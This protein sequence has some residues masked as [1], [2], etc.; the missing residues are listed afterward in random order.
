MRAVEEPK[1]PAERAS[2]PWLP[3]LVC[4][5]VRLLAF[6][7][8]LIAPAQAAESGPTTAGAPPHGGLE[9]KLAVFDGYFYV[10]IAED[11]YPESIPR[12]EDGSI[13]QSNVGFF[14]LYPLTVRILDVA[15]PGGPAI[16]ALLI[17]TA[18][19]LVATWLLWDLVRSISGDEAATR[20][21][22][23]FA[24]FPGA[25]VFSLAYTEAFVLALSIGAILAARRRSWWLAGVLALIASAT[26]PDALVLLVPL[27]WA[28]YVAVRDRRDWRAIAAPALA[29]LGAIAAV[30]AVDRQVG[31]TA[32]YLKV[33]NEAWG[34]GFDFGRATASHTLDVVQAIFGME[35]VT[36][37]TVQHPIGLLFCVLALYA[38]WRWRPPV[39]LWL[40]TLA[41]LVTAM[42]PYS[43]VPRVILRAFP[44][45]AAVGVALKGRW[46]IAVAIGF[47]VIQCVLAYL[48]VSPRALDGAWSF[49]P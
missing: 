27:G 31:E 7:A 36:F 49:I 45:V 25:F 28:A 2:R 5:A 11:G 4:G 12:L 9:G 17:S 42:N 6:I 26:R 47:A 41:S 14:P 24:V 21:A 10:S 30:L 19:A 29:P 44:L 40:Y 18:S 38:M 8:I 34:M 37:Y 48:I 23:L 39:D 46:F 33:Q 43:L 3:L 22:V 35:S 13:A 1:T 20:A 32:S 16:A 15:V